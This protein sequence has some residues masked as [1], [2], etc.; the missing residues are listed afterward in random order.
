MHLGGSYGGNY[1]A[2]ILQLGSC[3]RVRHVFVFDI[4]EYF[5]DTLLMKYLIYKVVVHHKNNIWQLILMTKN[6]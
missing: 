6:N 3:I 2:P 1:D 5:I 4:L